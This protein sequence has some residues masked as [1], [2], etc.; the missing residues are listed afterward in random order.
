MSKVFCFLPFLST[1]PLGHL[2]N[3]FSQMREATLYT[4]ASVSD[5]LLEAEVCTYVIRNS[6]LCLS[7]V[8]YTLN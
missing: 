8:T 6:V 4:L 7:L 5:Q 2:R 3:V 1:M